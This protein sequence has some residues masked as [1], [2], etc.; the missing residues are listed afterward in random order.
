MASAELLDFNQVQEQSPATGDQPSLSGGLLTWN[1]RADPNL[2]WDPSQSFFVMEIEVSTF[3]AGYNAG[4]NLFTGWQNEYLPDY[5][6]FHAFF[7]LRCFTSMTHIIDGVTVAHT[8]Q[9]FAD[10]IM[11]EKFLKDASLSN[12][13]NFESVN[14]ARS[15][16]DFNAA[17]NMFFAQ[18][19]AAGG[20]VQHAANEY[21]KL[22]NR[23]RIRE[24]HTQ[25]RGCFTVMF[26]PPFDMWTKHQ[27][28]SGGNHQ[29]Q[30]N[31]RPAVGS[32]DT[33]SAGVTDLLWGGYMQT[34]ERGRS[35]LEAADDIIQ[36]YGADGDADAIFG[37]KAWGIW[38]AGQGV[39]D[40]PPGG[41]YA[42]SAKIR[43]TMIAQYYPGAVQGGNNPNDTGLRVDIKSIRLMRRMVRFTVER[44]ISMEEFN[45]TE[46]A[47]FHGTPLL[48]QGT[49]PLA[50]T[51]SQTQ[52]F[53]LPA[54]T[55]AIGFYWRSSTDSY[56]NVFDANRKMVVSGAGAS[57][58][59]YTLPELR[60]NQFYFTYGGETYPSQRI[61]GI[62]DGTAD[63]GP[64][65]VKMQALTHMLQGVMNTDMDRYNVNYGGDGLLDRMDASTFL[66]PVS[67]HNN[68]DNSDLQ[69]YYDCRP[70]N[71]SKASGVASTSASVSLVCVAF[72]DARVELAYNAANQLEKV[73]KT[74]WK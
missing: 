4:S 65:A 53:L 61:A 42:L 9:P 73:T 3:T 33:S 56:Y 7:P 34:E 20:T 46:M 2:A 63:H 45:T 60:L 64:G 69:V 55:F 51:V 44:P 18:T 31:M 70:Q 57:Q 29:I 23:F 38:L 22:H 1:F 48:G 21:V 8:N 47:F 37:A 68:S 16:D 19:A 40:V 71:L 27:R 67:K 30:L 39:G 49:G 35:P 59:G 52:N 5:K 74:E 6:D 12:M 58:S 50:S 43:N 28:I 25:A 11:Q 10:K 26:Q 72:Y 17:H 24:A 66:F 15:I 36:Q 62:Y 13:S 14:L 32:R 54:S 41:G